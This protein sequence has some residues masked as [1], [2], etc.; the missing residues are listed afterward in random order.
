MQ[1][2]MTV[3]TPGDEV[4]LPSPYWTSYPDMVRIAQGVVVPMTTLPEH[5]YQISPSTLRHYLLTHPKITAIILCNPSN[6]TGVVYS[7]ET[8]QEMAIVLKDFPQVCNPS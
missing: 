7:K 6:P 1:A 4:L 2:L 3:I 5:N 8:L